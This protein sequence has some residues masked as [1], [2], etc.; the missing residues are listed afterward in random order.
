MKMKKILTLTM[1]FLLLALAA[2]S[3]SL[4]ESVENVRPTLEAAA[5]EVAEAVE[6]HSSDETHAVHWSYEGE[7][8]PENWHELGHEL[9]AGTTQSP[10]DLTGATMSDLENIRFE[11]GQTAVKI[12]NNEHTIQVDEID[13]QSNHHWRRSLRTKAVPFPRPQ[14][15]HPQWGA[16]PD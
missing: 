16:F 15:T 14:R 8:S 5:Q 4:P 7:G 10:I 3:G 11:Y 13:G 9:C 2:C 1:L 6:E 12:L